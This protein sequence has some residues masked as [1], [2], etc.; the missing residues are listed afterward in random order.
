[1]PHV[2]GKR[3]AD[4]RHPRTTTKMDD[5]TLKLAEEMKDPEIEVTSLKK[6]LEFSK[7][8]CSARRNRRW[9]WSKGNKTDDYYAFIRTLLLIDDKKSYSLEQISKLINTPSGYIRKKMDYDL[10]MA[11]NS[12]SNCHR[13]YRY[14][15]GYK[16]FT[17]EDCFNEIIA[18]QGLSELS[19]IEKSV[20]RDILVRCRQKGLSVSDILSSSTSEIM[21]EISSTPVNVSYLILKEIGM[22]KKV[23][24]AFKTARLCLTMKA[25]NGWDWIPSN[26]DEGTRKLCTRMMEL[27]SSK[28]TEA[29]KRPM[30]TL[31]D[32]NGKGLEFSGDMFYYTHKNGSTSLVS[33]EELRY[34]VF[35]ECLV[36]MS[37]LYRKELYNIGR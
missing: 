30:A 1:M 19:P 5:F 7:A 24:V 8:L 14:T 9:T 2:L 34:Y 32:V 13:S 12:S 21:E 16:G 4:G 11:R 22:R 10:L 31:R 36:F 23:T 20:A 37:E 17:K 29:M 3:E 18:T 6:A 26:V 25:K 35:E 15:I 27:Y 28:L 33:Y